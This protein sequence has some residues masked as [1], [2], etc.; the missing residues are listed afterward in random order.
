MQITGI[1]EAVQISRQTIL[2]PKWET[3]KPQLK[4]KDHSTKLP[5]KSIFPRKQKANLETKGATIDLKL[6]A[7]IQSQNG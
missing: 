7:L 5:Y 4:L 2:V 1:E 3:Q 6:A